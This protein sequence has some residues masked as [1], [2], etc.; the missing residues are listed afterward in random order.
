MP[1]FTTAR[2]VLLALL[3]VM[4]LLAAAAQTQ[5][6][7]NRRSKDGSK[8]SRLVSYKKDVYPIF[9]TYCL[10]CHTEDQM[11]PSELYLDTYGG[12]MQGGKHG[13]PVLPAHPDSSL[14]ML[15]LT[16]KPPFGDP[17]PLKRKTP[18][19]Q[20]TVNILKKWIGQGAKD[21]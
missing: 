19:P 10:P 21:N 3:G 1:G 14:L 8:A 5:K 12:L 20:D 15:K 11:N 17:M 6:K 13:T 16:L 9:R 4:V 18:I 2:I 7:T